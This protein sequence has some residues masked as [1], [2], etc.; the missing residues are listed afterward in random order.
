VLLVHADHAPHATAGLTDQALGELLGYPACCRAF[1]DDTWGSGQ[2]DSTY[3]QCMNAGGSADG[4]VEANMLWR[5]MGIR[6]VPHLP[7]SSTCAATVAL[8]QR[9]RE[10]ARAHGYAEEARVIDEVLGW[11][12]TWS[13][14]NGIAEIVGPCVKVSAR[15]DWSPELRLFKRSG[16]YLRPDPWLWADNGFNDADGMYASHTPIVLALAEHVA[17]AARVVDLG[18]GNGLLLKRL[19]VRRPDVRIAGVDVSPVAVTHAKQDLVGS[20]TESRIETLTFLA[21]APDA[22]VLSPVRL[23]EMP[24][25]EAAAVRGALAAMPQLFV[26][27]YADCVQDHGSLQG[28]CAHAGLP[29]PAVVSASAA[30]QV[31]LIRGAA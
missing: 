4:P 23:T 9:L 2:V 16:R 15:T 30:V 29:A 5:W 8:G 11:P 14:V 27:A 20:W 7:C 17:P 13:A 3:D 12:A 21:A 6:W 26:Y 28:L 31:G 25:A 10:V 19:K 22:A 24:A 18:C 1:F